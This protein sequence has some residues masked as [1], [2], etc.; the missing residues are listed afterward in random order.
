[1][2]NEGGNGRFYTSMALTL[3]AVILLLING[4]EMYNLSNYWTS[5]VNNDNPLFF[6]SCIKYDLIT[7]T[8]FTLISTATGLSLCIIALFLFCNLEYFTDKLLVTYLYFNYLVFGPYILASCIFACI[9]WNEVMYTCDKEDYTKRIVS[10]SNIFSFIGSLI[11]SL[12]VTIGVSFY[13]I[14]ILYIDSILKRP[15]GSYWIRKFF[16][17]LILKNRSQVEFL[18]SVAEARINQENNQG[19]I[20][21]QVVNNNVNNPNNENAA[22]FN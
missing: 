13:K 12:L 16:W 9:Y 5:G 3:C 2:H 15:D 17:G 22:L 6:E 14:L 7:K 19:N 4:V 10:M 21:I 8:V 1:M 18:R 11:F 20:N